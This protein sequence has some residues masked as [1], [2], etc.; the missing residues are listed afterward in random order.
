MI[1]QEKVQEVYVC[2]YLLSLHLENALKEKKDTH[3]SE[4]FWHKSVHFN[5]EMLTGQL[6]RHTPVEVL[7]KSTVDP[8]ILSTIFAFFFFI[9]YLRHI[10]SFVLHLAVYFFSKWLVSESDVGV[11]KNISVVSSS[12]SLVKV[13]NNGTDSWHSA[14]IFRKREVLLG[15]ERLFF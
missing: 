9:K 10:L 3:D 14:V 6:T 4:I 13:S 5:I 2:I 15:M 1:I 12:S 11:W 7:N 8:G